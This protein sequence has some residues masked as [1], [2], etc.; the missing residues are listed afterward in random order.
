MTEVAARTLESA[1]HLTNEWGGSPY[2]SL[3]GLMLDACPDFVVSAVRWVSQACT[4]C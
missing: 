1:S 4:G 2:D 3:S